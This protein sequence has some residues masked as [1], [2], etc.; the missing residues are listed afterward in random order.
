ML[1]QSHAIQSSQILKLST[2]LLLLQ[3]SYSGALVLIQTLSDRFVQPQWS[4]NNKLVL[5]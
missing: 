2:L 3:V 4:V 5:M 1:Q